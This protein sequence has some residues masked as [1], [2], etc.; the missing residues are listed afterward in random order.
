MEQLWRYF[1]LDK[2]VPRLAVIHSGNIYLKSRI[3]SMSWKQPV[4]D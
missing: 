2:V 1:S 3:L 4:T